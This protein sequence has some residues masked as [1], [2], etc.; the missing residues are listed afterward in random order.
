VS[1]SPG[2][3]ARGQDQLVQIPESFFNGTIGDVRIYNKARSASEV[4][5]LLNASKKLSVK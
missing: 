1:A 4:S 5:A 2:P 3:E